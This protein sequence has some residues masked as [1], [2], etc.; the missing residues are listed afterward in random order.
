MNR[1]I[2]IY[3]IL[4]LCLTTVI[5]SIIDVN[6]YKE[7][8]DDRFEN[9]YNV[10]TQDYI[11]YSISDSSA[12]LNTPGTTNL[13]GSSRVLTQTHRSYNGN[14]SGTPF[15]KSGKL[16]SINTISKNRNNFLKFP[17]GLSK[18]DHQLISLRKL[19]I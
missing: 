17:S 5:H 19:V 4:A 10:S 9:I 3:S 13:S 2:L 12:A 1:K 6:P 14:S 8:A 16:I 11:S 7:T 15:I 18:S